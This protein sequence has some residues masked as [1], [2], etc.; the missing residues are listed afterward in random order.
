MFESRV[1]EIDLL[2]ELEASFVADSDAE[3]VSDGDPDELS[4]I[5]CESV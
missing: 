2:M 4:E 5:V 1:D 3:R